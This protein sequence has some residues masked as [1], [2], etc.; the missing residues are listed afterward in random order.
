MSVLERLGYP[1]DAKLLIVHADDLGITHSVNAATTK[2]FATGL[3]NSGSVM[4]PCPWF[5]EIAEYAKAH[6]DAD[7]GLH[8]TLTSERKL[9]RWGPVSSK[10]EVGSLV[11]Q[12]GYFHRNW[13]KI[14]RVKTEHV[15]REIRAQLEKALAMGVRPTHIDSHQLALYKHGQELFELVV[16]LGHEYELPLLLSRDWFSQW[17]YL[18]RSIRSNDIVIDR[19]IDL[20]AP[21]VAEQWSQ[22]Y[23]ESL[24]NLP[25]GITEL[26]VHLGYDDEEM[27]AFS[28]DYESWGSAWR[29]RDFDFFTDESFGDILQ[30]YD[31]KLVTWRDLGRAAFG[32]SP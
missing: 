4:V 1:P 15:D 28:S 17:P 2:A 13:T 26:I 5:P 16:R 19:E 8:L 18:T 23:T 32:K 25:S 12:D 6:P 21:I 31:I 7:L 27:R 29:Q 24:A 22:W 14:T 10:D 20:R 3:V 11:D 9:Y 30:Q